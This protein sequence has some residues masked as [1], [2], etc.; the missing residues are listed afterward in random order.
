MINCDFKLPMFIAYGYVDE[1]L[2]L[3]GGKD[4]KTKKILN[5]T[6]EL[7]QTEVDYYVLRKRNSMFKSRTRCSTV[8]FTEKVGPFSDF[9]VIIG[10]SDEYKAFGL[11]ELYDAKNDQFYS[12]PSLNINRENSSVCKVLTQNG[13]T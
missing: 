9:I 13:E 5:T 7:I 10:G 3:F 4:T 8:S 1:R 11:C 6:Y 12:F 2:F